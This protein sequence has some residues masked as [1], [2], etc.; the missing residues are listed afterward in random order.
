MKIKVFE[1]EF[2]MFDG[3]EWRNVTVNITAI[4]K[5]Q[6][7]RSFIDETRYI[8]GSG[9]ETQKQTIKRIWNIVKK[10]IHEDMII[11]PIVRKK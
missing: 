10:D 11:F 1:L 7:M 6:L 2:D 3:V 5:I 8:T 9:V 4:S